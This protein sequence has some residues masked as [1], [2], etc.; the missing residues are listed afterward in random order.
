MRILF[1]DGDVMPHCSLDYLFKLSE[2]GLLKENMVIAWASE[3]SSGGFF[4]LAPKKGDYEELTN[5]IDNQQRKALTTGVVFDKVEGWGREIVP[6]DHWMTNLK[7]STG[8]WGW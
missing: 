4:M 2:E 3:P 5:I 7:S 8:E 6:P 1:F